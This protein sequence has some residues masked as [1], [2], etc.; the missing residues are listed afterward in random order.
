MQ[1]E[2]NRYNS[3]AI[4]SSLAKKSQKKNSE[5]LSIK[6][7]M[8]ISKKS[9]NCVH[10]TASRKCLNSASSTKTCS[11]NTGWA[12]YTAWLKM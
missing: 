9:L 5:A 3:P 1:F 7:F 4:F 12:K 8:I 10:K 2:Y 11:S 6:V